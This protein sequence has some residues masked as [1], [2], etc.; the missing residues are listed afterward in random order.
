MNLDLSNSFPDGSFVMISNGP[1]D[2]DTGKVYSWDKTGTKFDYMFSLQGQ[3]IQGND[4]KSAYELAVEYGYVGTESDWLESLTAYGMA[5]KN[6][7]VGSLNEWLES[8]KGKTGD[9]AYDLAKSEGFEG[10]INQWL[11]SLKGDSGKSAY[12]IAKE[13]GFE[14]TPKEWLESLRGPKGDQGIQG[15]QGPKGDPFKIT[16]TYYRIEDMEADKGNLESN[17]MVCVT[18]LDATSARIYWYDG[19]DF[20]YI[21]NMK[22]T[23][24]KG[25]DGKDAYDLAIEMGLFSGTPEEWIKSLKGETGETGKDA[26]EYWKEVEDKPEATIQE[27]LDYYRGAD[28]GDTTIFSFTERKINKVWATNKQMWRKVINVGLLLNP[29]TSTTVN[30]YSV[31]IAHEINDIEDVISLTGFAVY[32]TQVLPISY[33]GYANN[34][35]NSLSCYYN[36]ANVYVKV[37]GNDFSKYTAFLV[38]EYTKTSDKALS[39]AEIDALDDGRGQPGLSAY[40]IAVQYGEFTG[41]EREWL[42]SL[43]KPALPNGG[44]TGQLLVK[45]SNLDGVAGWQGIKVE[46]RTFLYEQI[47]A[48][49]EW[50][51]VHNLN[52]TEFTYRVISDNGDEIICDLEIVNPNVIKVLLTDPMSGQFQMIARTSESVPIPTRYVEVDQYSEKVF[53]IGIVHGDVNVLLSNGP[54]QYIEPDGDIN[55][56][57]FDWPEVGRSGG[58]TFVIKCNDI[59]YNLSF[60]DKILWSYNFE[61]ELNTYSYVRFS[62]FSDDNGKT[63]FGVV[64]GSFEFEAPVEEGEV[65]DV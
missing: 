53:N 47:S 14:G 19:N 34:S 30:D 44:T 43:M 54:V 6:G 28:G 18:D 2:P 39:Q 35:Q 17:I 52:T 48:S 20:T 33:I 9:S 1:T 26:F 36:G 7:Y 41:T 55:I 38:I 11:E 13:Q 16:K 49:T 56:Q 59:A 15:I 40:D 22:D 42:A 61:P 24:V 12:E 4:G 27:F 37:H 25:D 29:N 10:T 45:Q 51:I 63:Q 58:V 21:L 65:P 31:A 60:A 57:I 3:A 5:V 64:V 23:V 62:I 32:T 8:L 50:V 46:S